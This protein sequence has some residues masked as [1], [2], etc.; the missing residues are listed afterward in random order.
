M[1]AEM[2]LRMIPASKIAP[3]PFQPRESFPK[4]SLE[5]LGASIREAGLVQPI[6][7]RR[8]GDRFQI[9]A[10]ERRWRAYQLAGLKMIPSV[11]READDIEAR[12]LSL[13]ENWHRE[14]LTDPE[15]EKMVYSLWVDG[16]KAGRYRSIAHMARKFG[17]GEHTIGSMIRSWEDKKTR[18]YPRTTPTFVMKETAGLEEPIRKKAIEKIERG[19]VRKETYAIRQFVEPLK[20]APPAVKKAMLKPRSRVTP[21]VAKRIMELPEEKQSEAITQVEAL[22]LEEEEAIPHI[23]AMKVEVPLPPPEELE[24]IRERYEDL[25]KEI[26]AKLETP[27][28]K[29]RGELFRNWTSHI[30]IAGVLDSVFCPI[31]KS[32]QLGWVCHGLSVKEALEKAEKQYKATVKGG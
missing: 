21:A 20:R 29:E 32:K 10:G 31:C 19:E 2:E 17:V 30:A 22:R 28:A 12:E 25:Q 23:E 15:K 13:I 7:V 18:R 9:V 24:K 26:R 14:D 16:K 6:L 27:E 3:N 1:K 11:V 4:E 8:K 5:E